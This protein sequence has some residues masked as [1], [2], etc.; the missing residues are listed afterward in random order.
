TWLRALFPSYVRAPFAERHHR[1]WR[2]V[3]ALELDVRPTTTPV[4]IWPRGGAKS[5]SVELACVMVGARRQRRY[6][7]YLSGTQAQADVHLGNVARLLESDSIAR[8]YPRLGER[9]LGKY[10]NSQG[11]RR[12]RVWTSD[13]FVVDGLGL[14]VAARGVK[15]DEQ[16]PDLI[17][18]DDIDNV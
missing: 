14:D 16:R 13:G 10:G 1:F 18:I 11:W 15:L 4:L 8:H 17:V 3:W 7:W 12:E 6:V 5:T 9:K 2:W